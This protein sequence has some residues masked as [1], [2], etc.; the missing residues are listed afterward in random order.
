M[1]N[2]CQVCCDT[3]IL[4]ASVVKNEATWNNE[5]ILVSVCENHK[6]ASLAEKSIVKMQSSTGL[7][8]DIKSNNSK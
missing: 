4:S 2:E 5:M 8:I 7:P 1:N 3:G 6:D